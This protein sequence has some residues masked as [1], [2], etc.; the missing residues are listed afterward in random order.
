M[1]ERGFLE[2]I[3]FDTESVT[4]TVS[5][6]NM[7]TQ[8]LPRARE[9]PQ[10]LT[11]MLSIGNMFVG[12]GGFNTVISLVD[13]ER[14]VILPDEAALRNVLEAYKPLFGIENGDIPNN[15]NV[16]TMLAQQMIMFWNDRVFSVGLFFSYGL[17]KHHGYE[18]EIISLR[19]PNGEIHATVTQ[20]AAVRA[21]SPNHVNAWNF[22]KI[23]LTANV[24]YGSPG[25]PEGW[26]FGGN[27]VNRVAFERQV[28][29]ILREDSNVGT[30]EG[31]FFTP[32]VPDEDKVS[33]LELH[34]SIT[35][36]SLRNQT[37]NELFFAMM[38]PYFKG[39][40]TLDNAIENLRR[41]LRLYISE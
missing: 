37:V 16:N 12:F 1:G 20:S 35:S 25:S 9:I 8:V 36:A 14:G 33:F 15:I 34:R 31:A 28:A 29:E 41:R 23:L 21:S 3:G 30:V 2:E 24:Q 27:L 38:E 18:P 6:Y 40:I 26:A 22:I 10:F 13:F 39:E 19:G 11:P 17:M 32:A 5:F 4:D 7:L